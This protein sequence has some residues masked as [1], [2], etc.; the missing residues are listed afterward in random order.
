MFNIF[1]E[2][3]ERNKP[4]LTAKSVEDF[5]NGGYEKNV[6]FSGKHINA[7]TEEPIPNGKFKGELKGIRSIE[8]SYKNN[9]VEIIFAKAYREK[10][11]A[12]IIHKNGLQPFIWSKTLN[13][14]NFYSHNVV[15]VDVEN[16][17]SGYVLLP[18]GDVRKVDGKDVRILTSIDDT[19][20]PKFVVRYKI[21][22][23]EEW[24]KVVNAKQKLYGIKVEKQIQSFDENVVSRM[25]TGFQDKITITQRD[26]KH[27]FSDNA[28][29]QDYKQHKITGSF[30]NLLDFYRE[31]GIAPRGTMYLNEDKLHDWFNFLS[32]DTEAICRWFVHLLRWKQ[33]FNPFTKDSCNFNKLIGF[34]KTVYPQVKNIDRNFI[35]NEIADNP[36]KIVNLLKD[37][38]EPLTSYFDIQLDKNKIVNYIM[39]PYT[40]N[41]NM[42]TSDLVEYLDKLGIILYSNLDAQL[43]YVNPLEQYM[44]QTGRR[45]FKGIENYEDLDILTVDIETT[46]L[47]G[48]EHIDAAGLK[49]KLGRVFM[50]GIGDN[51]GYKEFLHAKEEHEEQGILENAYKIIAEKDPDILLTYNGEVFDFPFMEK[52]LEYLGC[53][54]EEY[55]GNQ[56]A[57][58][59]IR[60]IVAPYYEKYGRVFPFFM[61]RRN[62]G[63]MLKV[64]SNTEKFTQTKMYGKN[65]CDVIFAV[66]RASAIDNSLPNSQLKANIIHAGLAA[67]DRVYME[68]DMI[69][70]YEA[71][72]RPYYLNKETGAYFLAVKELDFFTNEFNETNVKDGDIGKFYENNN[73]LYIYTDDNSGD[74]DF[75]KN[76]KNT[77]GIPIHHHGELLHNGNLFVGKQ[78][79][80]DA[81][82]N[83]YQKT[84]PY[85][86]IKCPIEGIGKQLD[87]T[88]SK[89]V[90][91]H[92]YGKLKMIWSNFEDIRKIHNLIPNL[93]ESHVLNWENI[94][95][96]TG[97]DLTKKYLSG[98][99]EEPYLLD[100]L[101]SQST[102]AIAKWLPTKYE[103]IATMGTANVWKLLLAAWSFLNCIAI[104]D[105]EPPR[106]FTGGLLGMVSAGYHQNIVKID[107]SSLYPAE[108]L[109]HCATPDI[110][111]TGIYKMLLGVSLDSRLKFK[112]L[113]NKSGAKANKLRKQLDVIL[114]DKSIVGDE[115]IEQ[116]SKITKEIDVA[117]A[118]AQLYDK[119]QLPLKILINSFYGMLGAPRVSPFCHIDTAWHITCSGRQHM[120]HLIHYFKPLGFK[121]IYFHT[122]GA[123]FV[124]PP[125]ADDYRYTGKGKNWLVEKG[126]EY[127][128]VEAY[129]AE[130]NDAF[131]KGRMGVD[132]DDYALACINFS[133]GNFS[134]LKEKKGK[135]S[136]SHVGGT[137]SKKNQNE[138]VTDFL[139]EHLI[140]L[141]QGD[142]E[143]FLDAY[144]E[145]VI[146][147]YNQDIVAGKIA[148]K[149]RVTKTVIDY[150][151]GVKEGNGNRQAHMELIMLNNLEVEIGDWIYILNDGEGKKDTGNLKTINDCIGVFS[152][153]TKQHCDAA[154][155]KLSKMLENR[156]LIVDAIKK[157]EKN[158]QFTYKNEDVSVVSINLLQEETINKVRV[159]KKRKLNEIKDIENIKFKYVKKKLK[160]GDKHTVEMYFVS[161][162]LNAIIIS[163]EDLNT[164]IPYNAIKYIETFNKALSN[165]W[166]VFNLEIRNKIPTPNRKHKTGEDYDRKPNQ[167]GWFTDEEL[168][169][170]SG[171][172]LNDKVDKQQDID[173]L[174]IVTE[175]EMGFWKMMGLSPN[176]SFDEASIDM[177][178]VYTVLFNKSIYKQG[179]IDWE[180]TDVE[181]DNMV[182]YTGEELSNWLSTKIT[183]DIENPAYAFM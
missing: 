168:Q 134:Y 27:V 171:C 17:N 44:I 48:N 66:K 84:L 30:N 43:F 82:I 137:L 103:K 175:E 145:Y 54:S 5:L 61:Y 81:F 37:N 119:K 68:G 15:T 127:T 117:Q 146:K 49:P 152:F 110:D 74:L 141:F 143:G 176:N 71:D 22:S 159:S 106:E 85:N 14:S 150:I 55:R 9:T 51:K 97:S 46:A 18:N 183:L 36:D 33:Y 99:I 2:V 23:H 69:S 139:N 120:R 47:K 52:R 28:Y 93:D 86:L 26:K 40:F 161:R 19:E 92:L 31:G 91:E 38:D 151:R 32:K 128:G 25:A 147:I 153:E 144:Y 170:I 65:I 101:Y 172:P 39:E 181:R 133:K 4:T 100:K 60:N 111:I 72:K 75:L 107:Y 105:Y 77:F 41:G 179:Q 169:M 154:I 164:K 45:L 115:R 126:K 96:V 118:A 76:C 149:S 98:D 8:T 50:I 163:K 158:G 177:N 67:K 53:V 140:K 73:V 136:I 34:Y 113:K 102:F 122:D 94:E 21:T 35:N 3:K 166:I 135:L 130:Y 116:I 64:G 114:K 95:K 165:L 12:R 80:D 42:N 78:I 11:G 104:P 13:S 180:L 87:T 109:E 132:I 108:G 57:Q 124:I 142:G 79:L 29:F 16:L 89:K 88:L 131:M 20:N 182:T 148:N 178:S 174:L 70:F 24:K 6:K 90:Y 59:Y 162:D 121:I 83:F 10:Y 173:E 58:Q 123:N 155:A 138:F 1:K 56:T 62:E 7:F 63:A 125:N 167:R 129:V 157:S 112:G 156:E 160:S